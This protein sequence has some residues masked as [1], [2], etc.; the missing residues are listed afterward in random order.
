MTRSR[1][2][3][4][5]C[6]KRGLSISRMAPGFIVSFD[7]AVRVGGQVVVGVIVALHQAAGVA[8]LG[9]RDTADGDRLRMRDRVQFVDRVAR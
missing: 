9:R 3:S 1:I 8:R 4:I 5:E 7:A 6:F 2:V